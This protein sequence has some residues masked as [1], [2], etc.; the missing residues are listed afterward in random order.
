MTEKE[1]VEGKDNAIDAGSCLLSKAVL[2]IP[3]V[4]PKLVA[5]EVVVD[6][7]D[8]FDAASCVA[9]CLTDEGA[10]A[11]IVDFVKARTRFDST[12]LVERLGHLLL[13]GIETDEA[14]RID[15]DVKV[16]EVPALG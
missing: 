14:G 4:N 16:A 2:V 12:Q 11:R 15:N 7:V 1:K 8:N 3:A 9:L 13:E 6:A 10:L 5:L